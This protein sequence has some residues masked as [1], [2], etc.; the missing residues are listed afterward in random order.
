MKNFCSGVP[1]RL[2]PLLSCIFNNDLHEDV[3][4][5]ETYLFAD[6]LKVL[7]IDFTPTQNQIDLYFIKNW[8][9]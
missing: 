8:V 9:S 6:D 7:S 3:I 4:F 1:Q 2:L 5:S